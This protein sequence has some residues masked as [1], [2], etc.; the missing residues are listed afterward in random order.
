MFVLTLGE[1]SNEALPSGIFSSTAVVT[2]LDAL[3]RLGGDAVDPGAGDVVSDM[4]HAPGA[5]QPALVI[6]TVV[7]D[8]KVET[9]ICTPIC[10]PI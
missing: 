6:V 2:A 10:T 3:G 5:K 7:L 8:V 1:R 9:P 4:G